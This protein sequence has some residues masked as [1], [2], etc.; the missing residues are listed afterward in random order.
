MH[1]DQLNVE[2]LVPHSSSMSLLDRLIE[3]DGRHAV[4]EVTIRPDSMFFEAEKGIPIWI[5]IEYMA[6]T[7]AAMSGYD[8]KLKGKPVKIGLLVGCR[9]SICHVPFFTEGKTIRT[10]VEYVWEAEG[11]GVFDC[12]ISSRDGENEEILME[13]SINVFQPDNIE[14]YL[15]GAKI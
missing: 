5:G 8:S 9:K 1:P 7:I 4:S 10:A 14:N 6:Q 15:N 2:D 13:A 12:T 11:M 3:S